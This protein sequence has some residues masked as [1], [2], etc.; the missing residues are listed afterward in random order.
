MV[1]NAAE[2]L[3][4]ECYAFCMLLVK[5]RLAKPFCKHQIRIA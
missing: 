2:I 1:Q 4:G 3:Y 5:K